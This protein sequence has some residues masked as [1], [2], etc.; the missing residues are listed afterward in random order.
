MNGRRLVATPGYIN[1]NVS[2][3]VIPVLGDVISIPDGYVFTP[4]HQ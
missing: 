4:E 1:P 3:T 2:D